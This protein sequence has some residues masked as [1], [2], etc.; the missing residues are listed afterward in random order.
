MVGAPVSEILFAGHSG[1]YRCR[2]CK[3]EVGLGLSWGCSVPSVRLTHND[4][5]SVKLIH[6]QILSVRGGKQ[7]HYGIQLPFFD[8]NRHRLTN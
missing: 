3:A 5:M 8:S 7:L 6:L 2:F 1:L 4:A